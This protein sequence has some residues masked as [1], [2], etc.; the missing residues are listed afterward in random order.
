MRRLTILFGCTLALACAREDDAAVATASVDPT[1]AEVPP[2]AITMADFVGTWTME[3]MGESSDSVIARYQLWVPQDTTMWK[4]KF[5]H[6]DDTLPVHLVAIAGDSVTT[7]IGPYRSALRRDVM[8]TTNTT[9][10]IR[11]GV[12]NGL[13]VAHYHV[14]TPDSVIVVRARGIRAPQ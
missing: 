1:P 9:Y 2:A 3:S 10:H 6:Q 4:M 5:D 11:D 14:D 8:V 12:L 13:S 7:I